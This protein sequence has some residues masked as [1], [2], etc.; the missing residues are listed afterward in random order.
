MAGGLSRVALAD[1]G[2]PEA[3]AGQQQ[4]PISTAG[5]AQP[6]WSDDGTELYWIAPDATLM[7]AKISVEVMPSKRA[8]RSVCSRRASIL[9]AAS[10]PPAGSTVARDGRFLINTLLSEDSSWPIAVIQNWAGAR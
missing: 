5:G 6:H 3:A 10:R 1:T 7:A 9:A 4:W 8:C 2:R